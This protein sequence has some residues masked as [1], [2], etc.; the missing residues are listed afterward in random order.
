MLSLMEAELSL[1]R[2]ER[3]ALGH[4]ANTLA[5]A[6]AQRHKAPPDSSEYNSRSPSP[7]F[8]DLLPDLMAKEEAAHNA[9][10]QSEKE[11][12]ELEKQ[13]R[14]LDKEETQLQQEE[15]EYV[16]YYTSLFL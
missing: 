9:L 2:T 4:V 15:D 11:K 3:G 10:A 6:D 12:Y 16:I 13:L 1:L 7:S 14:Q 5:S 8:I